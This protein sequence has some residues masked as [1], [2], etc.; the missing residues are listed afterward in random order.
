MNCVINY[1]GTCMIQSKPLIL[2]VLIN[3]KNVSA[4]VISQ[5]TILNQA[6]NI[7][8]L[9]RFSKH[10][11]IMT[12][13]IR[14]HAN[15]FHIASIWGVIE[16]SINLLVLVDLRLGKEHVKSLKSICGNYR[17]VFTQV[18]IFKTISCGLLIIGALR[19]NSTSISYVF[20][21]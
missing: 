8:P 20:N 16:A 7:A 4:S 6:S 5:P 9:F 21:I 14:N 12:D 3:S 19:V 17:Y 11:L 2:Q 10:I 13:S 18:L 1:H 15:L